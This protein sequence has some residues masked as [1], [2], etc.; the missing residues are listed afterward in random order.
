MCA[1]SAP[2]VSRTSSTGAAPEGARGRRAAPPPSR[3]A[4]SPTS[5]T[6]PHR[7]PD[8]KPFCSHC[9]L[10]FGW[11]KNL[12]PHQRCTAAQERWVRRVRAGRL[13]WTP[14]GPRALG[15][16]ARGTRAPGHS[17]RRAVLPLPRVRAQPPTGSTWRDIGRGAHR[18]APAARAVWPLRSPAAQPGGP[19]QSPAA[20]GLRLRAV[21]P[22]LQP[23]VAP[24]SPPGGAH[25]QSAPRLRP[26]CA[27]SFSSKTNLVRPPGGAHRPAPFPC[28]QCGKSFS[29]K[30]HLV[31]HQRI[32]MV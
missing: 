17:G 10:S 4:V 1:R 20:L 25:G 13:L 18:R 15:L 27:R 24:G 30:T 9:G 28:P 8:S 14:A 2:E 26:W 22:P 12:A 11:K 3:R 19:L 7:L 16:R 31:R 5:P 23:Q 21:R 32:H 6:R 29:R